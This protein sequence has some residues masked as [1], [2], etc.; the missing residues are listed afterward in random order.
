[1]LSSDCLIRLHFERLLSRAIALW[2]NSLYRYKRVAYSGLLC[3][4]S[5]ICAAVLSNLENELIPVCW[6]ISRRQLILKVANVQC[7]FFSWFF[8][9]LLGDFISNLCTGG[10]TIFGYSFRSFFCHSGLCHQRSF[11]ASWFGVFCAQ[12]RGIL[13]DTCCHGAGSVFMC[14]SPIQLAKS[15]WY[16]PESTIAHSYYWSRRS[17]PLPLTLT[18]NGRPSDTRKRN[19]AGMSSNHHPCIFTIPS[20]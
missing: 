8:T 4:L 6:S 17:F 5:R 3:L 11:S 9:F 19:T 20:L 14:N 1:M 16:F 12:A 15:D 13:I 10:V 2:L 18:L 7:G